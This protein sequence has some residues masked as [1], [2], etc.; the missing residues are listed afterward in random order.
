LWAALIIQ[1][2]LADVEFVVKDKIFPAHKAILAARSPVFADEFEKIQPGK[3]GPHLIRIET[4]VQP[5]TVLNFL[6]FVYT[7]EPIGTFADEELLK[8]ADRYQLKIL[9]SLCQHALKKTDA[10]QMA[11]VTNYLN[12]NPEELYSSKIM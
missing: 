1:K 11:K 4:R 12:S 2:H 8:L 6:H 7:G 5:S 3:G 9:S 10:M